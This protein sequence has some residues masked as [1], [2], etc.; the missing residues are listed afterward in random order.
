MATYS[1][2][3]PGSTS[4]NPIEVFV[5]CNTS[6]VI[7]WTG[8]ITTTDCGVELSQED[9]YCANVTVEEGETTGTTLWNE[10][11]V[12]YEFIKDCTQPVVP[13]C[14]LKCDNLLAYPVPYYFNENDTEKVI[15]IHYSYNEI[16][17]GDDDYVGSVVK[18]S[19]VKQV[20]ATDFTNHQYELS[21]DSYDPPCTTTI[22]I[23][24]RSRGGCIEGTRIDVTISTNPLHVTYKGG[25]VMMTISLDVTRTTADCDEVKKRITKTLEWSVPQCTSPETNPKY[26]C[27]DNYVTRIIT[28]DNIITTLTNAGITITDPVTIYYRGEELTSDRIIYSLLRKRKTT[29]E[30]E[31]VCEAKTTYCIDQS[32]VDV[33]YEQGYLSNNFSKDG[34]IKSVPYTGGRIMVTWDYTATTTSEDCV[35]Y[36]STG[37]WKEIITIGACDERPTDCKAEYNLVVV[38]DEGHTAPYDNITFNGCQVCD[39]ECCYNYDG[40]GTSKCVILF[41]EMT[42]W[43]K[44]EDK[45]E[46]CDA[47]G[48]CNYSDVYDENERRV[49]RYNKVR[50][51]FVQDCSSSCGCGALTIDESGCD[52]GL[53]YEYTQTTFEFDCSARTVEVPYTVKCNDEIVD[54]GKLLYVLMCNNSADANVITKT[55]LG[56]VTITITQAGT[57]DTC[58]CGGGGGEDCEPSDITYRYN[59]TTFNVDC[60]AQTVSVP[61]TAVC[62]LNSTET[63]M[64]TSFTVSCNAEQRA[65]TTTNTAPGNTTITIVQAANMGTCDCSTGGDL[66]DIIRMVLVGDQY[67]PLGVAITQGNTPVTYSYLQDGYNYLTSLGSSYDNNQSKTWFIAN[68]LSEL[69]PY[70]EYASKYFSNAAHNDGGN[71]VDVMDATTVPEYENRNNGA[72]A[73]AKFKHNTTTFDTAEQARTE[74]RG[75]STTLKDIAKLRH[76]EFSQLDREEVVH[77]IEVQTGTSTCTYDGSRTVTLEVNTIVNSNNR[78]IPLTAPSNLAGSFDRTI[79]EDLISRY[80]NVASIKDVGG[81]SAYQPL[82]DKNSCN[83]YLASIMGINVDTY[84]LLMH[85]ISDYT[86][87]ESDKLKASYWRLR[88]TCEITPLDCSNIYP[89]SNVGV[90]LIDTDKEIV[91]SCG[92]R[93]FSG[94]MLSYALMGSTSKET[95]KCATKCGYIGPKQSF[96]SGHSVKSFMELLGCI[97]KYGD[98][99]NS[100]ADRISTYCENRTV[101]RAHWKTDIVAGRLISGIQIGFL[102]GFEEFISLVTGECDSSTSSDGCSVSNSRFVGG[103]DAYNYD[104]ITGRGDGYAPSAGINN[105]H[106]YGFVKLCQFRP[107]GWVSSSSPGDCDS[108]RAPVFRVEVPNCYQD[109]SGNYHTPYADSSFASAMEKYVVNNF[110]NKVKFGL[111]SDSTAKDDANENDTHSKGSDNPYYITV[112]RIPENTFKYNGRYYD[113]YV[114]LIPECNDD[115]WKTGDGATNPYGICSDKPVE[116]IIFCQYA[117]P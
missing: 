67:N 84:K 66:D 44:E 61:Y 3:G 41:K 82:K 17:E 19:G 58:S 86:K 109:S 117:H 28:K 87:K 24:A 60:N 5:G 103:G 10:Q 40:K 21:L 22:S 42:E 4:N 43:D 71:G 1:V 75:K 23:A 72:I 50:Y 95:S 15:D 55:A 110:I 78:I 98:D 27:R 33:Y 81:S 48:N 114:Y 9:T 69:T 76:E 38:D 104:P 62:E 65:K 108:L 63:A 115:W 25:K 64:T 70:T 74:L 39:S 29:E 13:S 7:C 99:N 36:S 97:E 83:G 73:Y 6:A 112:D 105:N 90:Y 89:S 8:R 20:K 34:D 52:Q 49:I 96:P 106:G 57:G 107:K 14:T 53:T 68:M 45:C 94:D 26:C 93:S 32:S 12:Y 77:A 46:S 2:V 59:K 35:T 31:N 100:K 54:T 88:P 80:G 111:N 11:I 18:K 56:D 79:T 92:S 51:E 85:K 47:D 101:V 30:C 113:I 102:N 91:E 116:K 16:C 37:N